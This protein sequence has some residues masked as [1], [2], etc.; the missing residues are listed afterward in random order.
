MYASVSPTTRPGS[1]TLCLLSPSECVQLL[2][3]E[4][5]SVGLHYQKEDGLKKNAD[6]L[7][8]TLECIAMPQVQFVSLV[9]DKVHV[10]T[11]GGWVPNLIS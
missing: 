9:D 5:K 1:V 4:W 6:S 3:K 11:N 8:V 10:G 2:K 7:P